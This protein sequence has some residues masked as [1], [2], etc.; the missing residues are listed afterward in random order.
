VKRKREMCAFL[1][2]LNRI[3]L[4]PKYDSI[5]GKNDLKM[6]LKKNCVRVLKSPRN[7]REDESIRK[8][9]L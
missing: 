5:K 8:K 1:P 3:K 4:F 6:S 2:T 7:N 9:K